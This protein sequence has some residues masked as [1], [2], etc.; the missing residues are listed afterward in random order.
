MDLSDLDRMKDLERSCGNRYLAVNFIADAARSLGKQMKDYQIMESK[1]IEWVIK[2]KCPYTE[3]QLDRMKYNASDHTVDSY[4][5]WVSD[6]SVSNA[7]RKA[8]KQSLRNRKLTL[9]EDSSLS[10]P[11][12]DRTNILLRMIWF[13]SHSIT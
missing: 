6:Q 13:S 9:C 10:K 12:L 5:E 11:R 8:Y 1:L 4:L 3:Q 2:G 7:V